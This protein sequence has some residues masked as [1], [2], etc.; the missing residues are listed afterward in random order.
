VR[1]QARR[2]YYLLWHGGTIPQD[3]VVAC[4]WP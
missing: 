3:F 1:H 4:P 2:R